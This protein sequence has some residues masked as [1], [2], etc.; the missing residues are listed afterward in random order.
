MFRMFVVYANLLN[1]NFCLKSIISNICKL[2]E[3]KQS[4]P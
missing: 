1:F 4:F 2:D 3:S